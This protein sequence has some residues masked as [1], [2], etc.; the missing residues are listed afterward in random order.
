MSASLLCSRSNGSSSKNW[1]RSAE[2]SLKR[3]GTFCSLCTRDV[4]GGDGIVVD[5]TPV[6]CIHVC[7]EGL[8]SNVRRFIANTCSK[9][10]KIILNKSLLKYYEKDNGGK[11]FY[12][13]IY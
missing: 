10:T 11:I 6:A 7:H 9:G 8:C 4:D 2:G 5:I 1:M 13:H 12:L 3:S